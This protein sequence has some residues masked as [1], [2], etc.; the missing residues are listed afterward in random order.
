MW[1]VASEP[2]NG[3]GPMSRD[4]SLRE[5]QER[6]RHYRS[7]R[8]QHWE[9]QSLESD[10]LDLIAEVGEVV[11]A[12]RMARI[13]SWK[14]DQVQTVKD[15][16]EAVTPKSVTDYV[17]ARSLG[18]GSELTRASDHLEKQLGDV[19]YCLISIANRLDVSLQHCIDQSLTTYVWDLTGAKSEK[20]RCS[21]THTLSQLSSNS[22]TLG[23]LHEYLEGDGSVR[24]GALVSGVLARMVVLG[25]VAEGYLRSTDYGKQEDGT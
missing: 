4:E 25:R 11:D 2:R 18:A 24:C 8:F 3:A 6:T 20:R 13:K 16:S 21:M 10:I 19:L 23:P 7:A 1:S 5:L 12:Y 9:E 15:K 22:A 14:P 17:Q